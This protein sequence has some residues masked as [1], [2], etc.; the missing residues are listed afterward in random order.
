MFLAI[1]QT[2][3]EIMKKL[4]SMFCLFIVLTAC[5]PSIR[6]TVTPTLT[7]VSTATVTAATSALLPVSTETVS[8]EPTT[9]SLLPDRP[10][11][12]TGPW[13]FVPLNQTFFAINPDGT[14]YTSFEDG[15]PGDILASAAHG[16]KIAYV[17]VKGLRYEN[18]ESMV[19]KL[20]TFPGNEDVVIPLAPSLNISAF[21]S[22]FH[23]DTHQPP[24]LDYDKYLD[25]A[26]AIG[27]LAWSPDGKYLAFTGAID[28]L[29]SDVYV[30]SLATGK[31]KRLTDS[32][33]QAVKLR[34]TPDS[35]YIVHAAATS[36]NI[37]RSGGGYDLDAFWAVTP[38]GSETRKLASLSS[39]E[40]I[41]GWLDSSRFVVGYYQTSLSPYFSL[42]VVDVNTGKATPW[43]DDSFFGGSY[44][45]VKKVFLLGINKESVGTQKYD[46]GLY[47]LRFGQMP[48]KI[49]DIKTQMFS[50][51]IWY[52]EINRFLVVDT[53][54][55]VYSVTVDGRIEKIPFL[56]SIVDLAISPDG[57]Y[58]NIIGLGDAFRIGD[59]DGH[60]WEI[61][62]SNSNYSSSIVQA[63]SADSRY[64]YLLIKGKFKV[65]AAPDFR[66]LREISISPD[67][68]NWQVPLWI[69]P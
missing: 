9:A 21:T 45:P 18:P 15:G 10:L 55:N 62:S 31:T 38:D 23:P 3:G 58:W 52:P 13:V 44:D 22:E 30:Y 29:T 12:A 34:W 35:R 43:F 7:A 1:H 19:L 59:W 37:G 5:Q 17:E 2:Q 60:I 8:A 65:I 26:F 48:E 49:S 69:V 53:D 66:T 32:I 50:G 63:W 42:G 51:V 16:N 56:N 28:G 4:F 27:E 54:D 36:L 64:C 57:K 6:P 14:G 67:N 33:T 47:L 61:A 11:S 40:H 25:T 39:D 20:R 41:L 46:D 24:K 68:F